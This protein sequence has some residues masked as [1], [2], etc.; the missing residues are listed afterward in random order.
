VF[1]QIFSSILRQFTVGFRFMKKKPT[2]VSEFQGTELTPA[3]GF[4][5][6]GTL[7]E[8]ESGH[9]YI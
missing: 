2:P 9:P 1:K 7:K 5:G 6:M 8:R 4:L 3:S